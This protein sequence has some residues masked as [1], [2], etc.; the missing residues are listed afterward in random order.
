MT[1]QLVIS[2]GTKRS[3]V[4]ALLSVALT[5]VATSIIF[6]INNVNPFLAFIYMFQGAFG[7]INLLSETLIRM[8]PILIV[9]LGLAVSFKCKIWNIGAEGQLY[10]GAMLGTIVAIGI[11]GGPLAL[12]AALVVGALGGL[13]WAA[14]PALMKVKLGINEVITTFL[15]NFVGIY[16][17]QWMISYPFRSPDTLFPESAAIPSTSALAVILPRTRLHLGVV[18]AL[19]LVPVVYFLLER[20][21]FGY[22]VKVVGE[23]PEAARYG[24]IEVGRMIFVSLIFS[25]LLAGLAGIT[26]VMGIQHRVRGSLSPGYGYTGIVVALLGQNNPLG[27]A[28]ASLFLAAIMNGSSTLAWTMNIPMGIVDL[29]QGLLFVFVLAS[30]PLMRFLE[31]RGVLKL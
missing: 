23:S 4:R 20:T 2:R 27:V 22:K 15:M 21:T 25:G 26:E 14:G 30:E 3:I 6:L 10:I 31:R 24:G 11:G 13:L 19:A 17:V 18:L 28:L 9:S 29:M 8:T 16:L 5:L 7:D 12:L 1:N